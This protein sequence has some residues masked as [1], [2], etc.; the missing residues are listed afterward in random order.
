MPRP[1][2]STSGRAR[3]PDAVYRDFIATL[4]TMTVPI[5]G[6]GILY[7]AVGALI[8]L[9][10]RDPVIG[11]LTTAAIAVTCARVLLIRGYHR[12]GGAAQAIPKLSQW[13]KRYALMTYAFAILLAGLNVRALTVH[14]PLIHLTTISLVFTFG[15]GIVSRNASR[16]RLCVVSLLLAVVPTAAAL[17]LHAFSPYDELLHAQF[18]ALEA[19]LLLAVTGMSFAS[20]RHL[21]D[22]S[23]DH[24]TTK[25]DLAKLARFDALTGLPNRLLLREAFQANLKLGASP[26]HLAVHYLDLDGFKAINDRYGHPAGDQMLVEVARRLKS[27][28]RSTD[29]ACRLGG[30]EF[31]LL[32]SHV[33]HAHHADLLARRVI[34]Q[35]GEP[36]LIDGIEMRISASAG[37]A[38]APDHGSDLER[39]IRCADAALYRSKARGKAQFQ[40]YSIED[41]EEVGRAVA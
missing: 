7:A 6:F 41:D 9:K 15:A 22:A 21:Y 24:L 35:L 33:Q 5:V 1:A 4:F 39:L 31:L 13:E 38:I 34:K 19:I 14:Q 16:P 8:C 37:I 40:F 18:F 28:V 27:A 26:D 30:D 11:F 36:Y 17:L 20:V 12:A 29:T 25:H 10:W 2:P 3:L 32:Q 23:V